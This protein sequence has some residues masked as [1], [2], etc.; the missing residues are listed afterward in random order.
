MLL[1]AMITAPPQ[2][3]VMVAPSICNNYDDVMFPVYVY[4]LGGH[5]H[6]SMAVRREQRDGNDY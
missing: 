1:L 3:G 4:T 2:I 6:F 5:S